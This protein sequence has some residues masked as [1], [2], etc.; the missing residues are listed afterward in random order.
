[1]YRVYALRWIDSLCVLRLCVAFE[2]MAGRW[3]PGVVETKRKQQF[4]RSL[5]N[6][7]RFDYQ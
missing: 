4:S 7:P 5:P 2:K 1:M 3:L 6:V